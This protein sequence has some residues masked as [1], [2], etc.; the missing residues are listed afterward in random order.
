MSPRHAEGRYGPTKMPPQAQVQHAY[1][2]EQNL[3]VMDC[4]VRVSF[5]MDDGT[6]IQ[7]ELT[8]VDIPWWEC[9]AIK[10][11]NFLSRIF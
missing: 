5:T 7:G 4:T 6:R 1:A 10:V 9:V 3:P 11:G 8:F 2:G